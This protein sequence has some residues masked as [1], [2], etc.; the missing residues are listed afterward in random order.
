MIGQ[1]HLEELIRA[2]LAELGVNVELGTELV[3]FEQDD[4][5]VKAHILRQG[6]EGDR[7]ETISAKW[8][9]SAEG[10]RST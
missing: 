9:V 6:S 5:G 3:D 4:T 7:E 1:S 2:H 8:I 10:G